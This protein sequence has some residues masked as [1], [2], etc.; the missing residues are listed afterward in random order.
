MLKMPS[1]SG[2]PIL[3]L[4]ITGI[5]PAFAHAWDIK[6]PW[7]GDALPANQYMQTD[8]HGGA[9]GG[10]N[11]PNGS[12]GG[13]GNDIVG[14][15]W[16]ASAGSFS[17]AKSGIVPN[18]IANNSTT[19]TRSNSVAWGM[20]LYSPVDGRIIACWNGIDDD[21]EDGSDPEAC[22]GA[23][24]DPDSPLNCQKSGNMMVIL[25]DDNHLVS[26]SH[27]KY[28]SIPIELCPNDN[29]VVLEVDPKPTC[30]LTGFQDVARELTFLDEPI[31]VMKG[32]FIGKVG[33]SGAA[34]LPHLHLGTYEYAEDA[35]GDPC[36]K[37]IPLEFAETWSQQYTTTVAPTLLNW[38]RNVG[39]V[40]GY[41]GTKTYLLW[42]D[43]I[44][45]V[46]DTDTL[47]VSSATAVALT[48]TGGVGAYQ[49]NG[50]LYLMPFNY[51][52]SGVL[53]GGSWDT[54]SAVDDIAIARIDDSSDH[55]VV[56]FPNAADK[57]QLAPYYVDSNHNLIESANRTELTAG[58]GQVEATH[59]PTPG[60]VVVAL[61]NSLDGISVIHYRV[62]SAGGTAL[63][64]TREDDAESAPA[65]ADLDIATIT[66]GRSLSELSGAFK[67]V[68]TVE[69]TDN[70]ASSGPV[71]LRTWQIDGA[72]NITPGADVL[73]KDKLTGA[74]ISASE[75]DVTVTG[76][77]GREF[78][79]VSMATSAGLRVQN[80]T[81]STLGAL[82]RQEQYEGGPVTHIDSARVGD[83]DA[84]VGVRI[85]TGQM[86]LLSFHVDLNGP[87]RRV[88][89][90]DGANISSILLDGNRNSRDLVV[91]PTAS[92]TS[93][94]S[95]Q[96][97]TTNYNSAL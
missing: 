88:G 93:V 30:N 9:A 19:F 62:T 77:G 45:P 40:L 85:S 72:H 65:V 29:G 8:G 38:L 90:V 66:Q 84:V 69:R 68:V 49:P 6:M 79:V 61:K 76:S 81:V 12:G 82:A 50:T 41:D 1:P 52:A 34:A 94:V 57:L 58:V 91:M 71:R 63:T 15:R 27:M 53:T 14:I 51:T 73:V 22:P 25:T 59:A 95:M 11:C 2:L 92:A 39:S 23:P 16:D 87:L 28:Q 33:V 31:E 13:C 86:S 46:K 64:I 56:V 32:D 26:L 54:M 80:W 55:V 96:H 10:Y 97:Y 48:A 4:F 47:G 60:G 5:S 83:R 70:G 18:I 21:E 37:G 3:A 44:G 35:G 67:G 74:N 43:P 42:G 89:T 7:R 17:F 24:G 78:V 20:E 75:V 36:Q